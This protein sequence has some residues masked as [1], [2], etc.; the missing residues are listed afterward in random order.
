LTWWEYY[1]ERGQVGE[2]KHVSGSRY[3]KRGMFFIRHKFDV[4]KVSLNH[5]LSLIQ[6]LQ[7]LQMRCTSVAGGWANLKM[8]NEDIGIFRF[9]GY[10]EHGSLRCIRVSARIKVE[11]VCGER[12]RGDHLFQYHPTNHH[13]T[14][15][16]RELCKS[17]PDK[18]LQGSCL[19]FTT[20]G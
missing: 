3:R 5:A 14:R 6:V 9:S 16:K 2:K 7:K 8:R 13:L 12:G 20:I 19:H 18:L 15:T 10:N 4:Q 11:T 1:N 17:K